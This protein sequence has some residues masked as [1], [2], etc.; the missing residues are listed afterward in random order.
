LAL[1]AFFLIPTLGAVSAYPHLH[2]PELTQL[3]AWAR[4]STPRDAVFLFADAGKQLPPGIFRAEAQ[5]A[6]Y[7]DWKGGGQV[8]YLTGFAQQWCSRW[9]QMMA[10]PYAPQDVSRY[11]SLGIDYVVLSPPHR[12]P[13]RAPVFENS[14]YVAYQLN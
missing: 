6:V 13:E 9:S 1:V 12:L 11:R 2:T 3:S 7:V 4:S 10:A 14:R 5:R 8:N